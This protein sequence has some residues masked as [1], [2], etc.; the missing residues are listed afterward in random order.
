MKKQMFLFFFIISS[1]VNAQANHT[2][3][4]KSYGKSKNPAII[5]IHGGPRGNSTLFEGTTAQKLATEGFYVI[6]YDRRGEG[7]SIDTTATFTYQEAI[8]DLNQ[9]F[10]KYNIK[11][12]N[13]IAHS[14]GGLVGTLYTEQNP[15]KVN[16][17]ILAGALFSQQDTYDQILKTTKE[18][19]KEKKDTL[20]LSKI[21]DIEKLPKNSAE[22]RKRCYEVASKNNYFKMPFPTKE[23]NQLRE[24]YELSEF[25]KNNIRN[26]YAP[27][28]FYKNESK[29]NIDT[30]P[31]LINLKKRIK[32][33]AIY[34]QQD[35]I[36]S[37]NQLSDMEK[38]V[39]KQNFKL[40]ENCSHYMF[41]DQQQIFINTIVRWLKP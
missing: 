14:F 29:N 32:L 20:M 26:D 10:D 34:G 2:L 3:Y 38:I 1:L 11:K 31:I 25:G 28:L 27:I 33:F 19:Y 5:F 22:Y 4:S 41:V 35:A 36:F 37:K 16:S 30:K 40:I 18:I 8:A 9:I 7:R 23:A 15:E 39:S 6:V 13:I 12:A 21:S 24:N 17:L